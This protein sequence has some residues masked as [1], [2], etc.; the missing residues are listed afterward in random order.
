MLLVPSNVFPAQHDN[1]YDLHQHGL[2]ILI[3][4]GRSEFDQALLRTRL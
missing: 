1:V 3:Q 2:A 4:G